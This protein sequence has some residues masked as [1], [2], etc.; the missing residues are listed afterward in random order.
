MPAG[1]FRVVHAEDFRTVRGVPMLTIEWARNRVER[2]RAFV[3][4]GDLELAHRAEDLLREEALAAIA[5]GHP[6][7]I[8]L[9]RIVLEAAAI[10][11]TRGCS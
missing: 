5:D 3:R 2:I 9:A 6:D 10:P 11:Y 7:P 8:A 1:T 4:N